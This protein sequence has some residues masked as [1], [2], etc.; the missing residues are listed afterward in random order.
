MT[1]VYLAIGEIL[2]RISSSGMNFVT[3][4]LVF[5]TSC[6]KLSTSLVSQVFVAD[7]S[8]MDEVRVELVLTNSSNVV[9]P[10]VAAVARLSKQHSN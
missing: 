1:G 7:N 9:F 8:T 5:F 6:D 4:F 10:V 2:G 3:P